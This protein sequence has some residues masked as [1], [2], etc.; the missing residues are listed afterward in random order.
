MSAEPVL[1]AVD[2]TADTLRLLLAE[3]DGEVLARERWPLP[4]VADDE[5]WAGEVGG[6]I[7]ALF[8]REGERRSALAVA[9]STSSSI[10]G[11]GSAA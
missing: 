6:R 8:A 1:V 4:E 9:V 5:A 2:F 7:A 10:G 11:A 3:P